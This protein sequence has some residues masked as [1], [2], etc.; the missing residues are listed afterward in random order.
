MQQDPFDNMADRMFGG[1]G[2]G[3]DDP[4]KNDPFFNGKGGF[5]GIDKIMKQSNMMMNMDGMMSM[6][7]GKAG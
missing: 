4:F 2:M 1:F 7:G 5:G 3:F 6:G